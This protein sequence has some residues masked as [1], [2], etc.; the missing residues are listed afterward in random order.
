MKLI[1]IKTSKLPPGYTGSILLPMDELPDIE[2]GQ[3]MVCDIS[4]GEKAIR[5]AKQ[6][7]SIHKYFDLLCTALNDAG[8]DMK[9]VLE[10]LSKNAKIPWSPSAI[11]ERLWKPVQ[12]QTYG[13]KSTAKLDTDEVSIVYEALNQI[14][15][16]E[17]GVSVPFP[18]R[19]SLMN[20]QLGR[21]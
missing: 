3:E 20:Q 5:T 9:A 21:K 18:D 2:D 13:K 4:T 8:W 17:L 10:K 16:E 14:T 11:K 12:Q 1:L 15:G 7:N 19:Y 6:N